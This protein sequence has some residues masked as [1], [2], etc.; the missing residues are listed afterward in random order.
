MPAAS[1]NKEAAW[2]YMH[3][4]LS[5]SGYKFR[6]IASPARQSAWEDTAK[7]L[8]IPDDT[9]KLVKEIMADYASDDGVL[10]LPANKKIVDTAAPIWERA[11]LGK[12][13][14]ND[15]LKEIAAK[16]TPVLSENKIA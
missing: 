16:V 11:Q 6:R 10:R 13:G 3:E 2:I 15:A 8:G 12:I 4:F 5:A 9:A 7:A 14:V 1:K